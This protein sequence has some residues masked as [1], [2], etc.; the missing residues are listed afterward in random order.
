[1]TKT[2]QNGKK[3]QKGKI[4]QKWHILK[5]RHIFEIKYKQK[6]QFG[7]GNNCLRLASNLK[8]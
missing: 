7:H 5:K 3:L 8:F 2:G 1:M 6:P 4:A